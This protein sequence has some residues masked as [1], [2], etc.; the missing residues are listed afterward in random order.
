MQR[1]SDQE[2]LV[3]SLKSVM[4]SNANGDVN[5]YSN[6]LSRN[7]SKGMDLVAVEASTDE[8]IN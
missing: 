5:D 3:K 6:K 2:K 4:S 1:I 7:G 8:L